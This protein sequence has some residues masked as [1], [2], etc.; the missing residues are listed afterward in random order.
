M[1]K[2]LKVIKEILVVV[3]QLV[4]KVLQDL[5]VL[6]VLQDLV[7]QRVLRVLLA[8]VGQLVLKV[9]KVQQVHLDRQESHQVL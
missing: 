9:L 3:G 2:V 1:L 4:H 7:D 5:L 6:K 8:V